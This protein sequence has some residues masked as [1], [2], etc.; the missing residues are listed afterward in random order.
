MLTAQQFIVAGNAWQQ[1][2]K[3]ICHPKLAGFSKEIEEIKKI[4]KENYKKGIKKA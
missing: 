2:Q 1:E 3:A 4:S